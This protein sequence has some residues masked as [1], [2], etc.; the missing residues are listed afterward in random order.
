MVAWWLI[1]GVGRCT[2]ACSGTSRGGESQQA[3][4]ADIA[5]LQR[6]LVAVFRSELQSAKAEMVA[7]LSQLWLERQPLQTPTQP[8]QQVPTQPTGPQAR[9]SLLKTHLDEV[10]RL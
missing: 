9:T 5:R 2:A 8:L 1:N 3:H 4:Q 10:L 6:E 7:Q